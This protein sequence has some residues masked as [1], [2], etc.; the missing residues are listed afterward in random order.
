MEDQIFDDMIVS[1]LKVELKQRGLPMSGRKEELLQRLKNDSPK[2][3]DFL[4]RLKASE[5]VSPFGSPAKEVA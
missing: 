4:Q 1:E 2:K 3:D 5:E